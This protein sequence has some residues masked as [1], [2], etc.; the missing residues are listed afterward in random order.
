[1]YARMMSLV[2]GMLA[3]GFAAVLLM[4]G[5]AKVLTRQF[6]HVGSY[7]LDQR[8]AEAD[9]FTLVWVMHAFSRPYELALGLAEVVCALLVLVPRTRGLGALMGIGITANLVILN[10]EYRIGAFE[11]AL[12]LFLA[13]A[14]I[15]AIRWRWLLMVAGIP[16]EPR[17]GP[18]WS[19][20]AGAAG[21]LAIVAVIAGTLGLN[22]RLMR[23][24]ARLEGPADLRGRYR[25]ESIEPV[26]AANTFW[27]PGSFI[28]FD[29]YGQMGVRNGEHRR[30]G[31]CTL[32][33][34][35]RSISFRI[36]LDAQAYAALPPEQ[37]QALGEAWWEHPLFAFTGSYTL[38]ADGGGVVLRG[39][40]ADG[41]A[42]R[43]VRDDLLWPDRH[44]QP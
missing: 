32:D 14:A 2:E 8:I 37:A 39:G 33:P 17:P 10:H 25:V 11:V 24:S 3:A 1:M 43:L 13:A 42:V 9:G 7:G 18:R 12:G 22:H 44:R 40:D 36:V 30:P 16:V 41:P 19:R 4:Y 20:A 31:T 38:D 5:W 26:T 6:V 35:S 29:G 27:S 21:W 15:L 23:E 34:T 28:Y